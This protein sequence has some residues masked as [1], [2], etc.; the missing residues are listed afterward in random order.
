MT[1]ISSSMT[2]VSKNWAGYKATDFFSQLM[3]IVK[4]VGDLFVTL[5]AGWTIL[6]WL[7]V[8]LV[9]GSFNDLK[10]FSPVIFIFPLLYLYTFNKKK[11]I[12]SS[13]KYCVL[14][15]AEKPRIKDGF[16]YACLL[17]LPLILTA[18]G[19]E[20]FWIVCVAFLF[21]NF[22]LG[23]TISCSLGGQPAGGNVRCIFFI[24][25]CICCALIA[26]FVHRP[27]SDDGFFLNLAVTALDSPDLPL[28]LFDGTLDIP[29]IPLMPVYRIHSFELF[30][31]FLASLS[32]VEPIF[33]AHIILPPVM[34][35]LV[36]ITNTQL[37]R[38]LLPYKWHIGCA[39]L[40]LFWL[41]MADTHEG[42][43]NYGLVRIFQGKAILITAIIPLLITNTI[44]TY[45]ASSLHN[46]G[47]LSA[48]IVSAV[49]LS[50]SGLFLGPL[51]VAF[52][53]LSLWISSFKGLV[54]ASVPLLCCLVLLPIAL[55]TWSSMQ[56][57]EPILNSNIIY[58]KYL[59][60]DYALQK[61]FGSGAFYVVQ[62]FV[63]ISCWFFIK[64]AAL[65]RFVL[66]FTL[67]FF[68]AVFNPYIYEFWARYITSPPVFFRL[69]FLYP[70]PVLLSCLIVSTLYD[71]D[72]FSG[73]LSKCFIL[74]L[75]VIVFVFV[76]KFTT[77]STANRVSIDAPYK[78]KVPPTT[79]AMAKLANE[80][81][82]PRETI[83]APRGIAMWVP[84]FRHHSKLVAMKENYLKSMLPWIGER[85]FEKRIKLF[86][87]VSGQQRSGGVG[88]LMEEQIEEFNLGV[89]ITP[90]Q[91]PWKNEII[92]ISRNYNFEVGSAYG[93]IV[94]T[95]SR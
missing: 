29:N 26:A 37:L 41:T 68:I 73:R 89:I 86:R 70:L 66:S 87:Y 77:L 93:Y 81:V 4:A 75:V 24:L 33:V 88:R 10:I 95:K 42:F 59:T 21:A 47:V 94:I 5:F 79:Y 34:G 39:F 63:L 76:P 32:N 13:R 25:F 52:V 35:V 62:L 27:D 6:V 17:L 12:S 61:V 40:L 90:M 74:F 50:S 16:N 53:S 65:K 3:E 28:L 51:I 80:L 83:L 64:D 30:L 84:T 22:L 46:A 72:K 92:D 20:F 14:T 85:E 38:I 58:G 71:A 49:G 56:I 91:N 78:L 57:L 82:E 15:D 43:S 19:F 9:E 7:M 1:D 54:R 55:V 8:F 69:F 18:F 23:V 36:A 2:A 67:I 11:K 45:N 31:A 44:R 60:L 48:T